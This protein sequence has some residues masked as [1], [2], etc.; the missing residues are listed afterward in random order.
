EMTGRR[1]AFLIG[2]TA[3][4]R[5]DN[6][7]RLPAAFRAAGWRVDL[8][9]QESIRLEPSGV[10]LGDA[11]PDRYTLIWLLGMG[12]AHTFLDRMQLLRLLPQERFV[13]EVDA[14]VYR[15][16]KYPWRRWMP[17]THASSDLDYLTRLLE[18]GG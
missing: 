15:H 5:H 14:L 8:L 12:R 10:R 13:I 17:E 18:S 2:D 6:H 4:A 1:I 3:L 16:A 7:R 11:D 9:P